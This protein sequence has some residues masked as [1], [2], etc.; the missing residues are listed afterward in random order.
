MAY[1]DRK[2]KFTY[3][4][5]VNLTKHRSS[6]HANKPKGY[7][8]KS[9]HCYTYDLLVCPRH[10]NPFSLVPVVGRMPIIKSVEV[11][12]SIHWHWHSLL[13][14]G[15]GHHHRFTFMKPCFVQDCKTA[16]WWYKSPCGIF[17]LRRLYG[18]CVIINTVIDKTYEENALK[19][20]SRKRKQTHTRAWVLFFYSLFSF[21]SRW[22]E[23]FPSPVHEYGPVS[24][25]KKRKTKTRQELA[26]LL[27]S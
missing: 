2:T 23:T 8:W 6:H 7:K 3:G 4:Y 22:Y 12:F 5:R 9:L 20:K 19:R 1:W 11:T 10:F 26:A 14:L 15:S 13:D 16:W 24:A 17:F 27:S 25:Q 21:R 18:P